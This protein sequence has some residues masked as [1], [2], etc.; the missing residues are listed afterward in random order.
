[1]RQISQFLRA[2]NGFLSHYC[3]ACF[4]MHTIHIDQ[5]NESG[6]QWQWDGNIVIP[7]FSPSIRIETKKDRRIISCC[8]YALIAGRLWFLPDCTHALKD[9]KMQLPAVP[10]FLR[11]PE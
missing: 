8:H 6:C 9:V 2:G 11:R 7:T 5:P 10:M 3:P 4:D 1:M